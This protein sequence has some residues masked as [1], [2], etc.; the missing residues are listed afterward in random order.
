MLFRSGFIHI[1]NVR[2]V[3]S[4]YRKGI[5]RHHNASTVTVHNRY[6]SFQIKLPYVRARTYGS[7][8]LTSHVFVRALALRS[9]VNCFMPHLVFDAACS[10]H[11]IVFPQLCGNSPYLRRSLTYRTTI[12]FIILQGVNVNRQTLSEGLSIEQYS[13][14]E[15]TRSL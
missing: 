9:F 4:A 8:L 13:A 10:Y 3:L 14:A 2:R 15:G 11:R 5:R 7:D 12:E 1:F 6:L